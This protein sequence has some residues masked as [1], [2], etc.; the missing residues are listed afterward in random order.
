MEQIFLAYSLP[1]ETVAA[2][3]MLSKNM[4]VK[5]HSPDGDTDFFE[6][7]TGV[8]R[9]DTLAP[10]MFIICQDY[11]LQTSIDLMKKNGLTLEM[12]RSKLY[13]A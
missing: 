6:I 7:V 10:Y 5:V 3:R 9:R 8:L 2:I 4:K 12:A 13:S 1:R 11:V